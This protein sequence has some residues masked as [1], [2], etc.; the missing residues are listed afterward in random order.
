MIDIHD[1]AKQFKYH[2]CYDLIDAYVSPNDNKHWE[3]CPVCNALPKIWEYNNGRSTGCMCHN[4][5]YDHFS[6]LAESIMS[7]LKN[8]GNTASYDSDDLRKNWNNWC[9]TGKINFI[10]NK[11]R[12]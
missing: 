5:K 3:K 2:Y 11:T 8:N 4:T 9:K 7:H 12:W 6:I 1:D 10:R